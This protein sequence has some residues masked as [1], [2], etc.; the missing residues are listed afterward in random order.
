[1]SKVGYPEAAVLDAELLAA[2]PAPLA[3]L[4]LQLAGT[5]AHKIPHKK[6]PEL[7]FNLGSARVCA[8]DEEL[9]Y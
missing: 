7:D 1:M 3:G 4:L 9:T 6:P 5:T 8:L 2:P